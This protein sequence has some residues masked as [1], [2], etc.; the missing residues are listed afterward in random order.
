MN[1]PA[2]GLRVVLWSAVSGDPDPRLSEADILA[3][4]AGRVR[5]GGV[6]V[7]HANG[8]GW[9]TREVVDRLTQELLQS[10]GLR[11]VTVTQLL[12][13]CNVSAHDAPVASHH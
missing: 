3:A 12:D 11:L 2:R 10:Q 9:H 1:R 7:F 8:K 13:R 6:V 4:L 5:D